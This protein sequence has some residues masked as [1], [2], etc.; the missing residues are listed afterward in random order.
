MSQSCGAMTG[1]KGRE[2]E[3]GWRATPA[4]PFPAVTAC[5]IFLTVERKPDIFL[6]KEGGNISA[7]FQP[8]LEI[9]TFSGFIC[10]KL[11]P[12]PADFFFK[13]C[14][15]LGKVKK[16][17]GPK[18]RRLLLGVSFYCLW[19]KDK[20][21]LTWFVSIF[22]P[23][24]S[25]TFLFPESSDK[26]NTWFFLLLW[27]FLWFKCLSVWQ[28]DINHLLSWFIDQKIDHLRIFF[29]EKHE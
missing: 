21:K 2:G 25:Q 19:K 6:R 7:D 28:S 27:L 3:G 18:G 14:S 8:K 9:N 5:K 10:V 4:T 1:W 26:T 15:S 20:F 23:R 13:V 12:R 16:S 24:R 17:P 29:A 11:P 22:F